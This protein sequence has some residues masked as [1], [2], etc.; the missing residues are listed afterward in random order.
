MAVDNSP[1]TENT[2]TAASVEQQQETGFFSNLVSYFVPTAHADDSEE[3]A[4]EAGGEDEEKEEEE[5]DEPEDHA[6]AIRNECEKNACGEHLNLFTH[7][8]EK[9]QAGEGFPGEDCV[10]ELFHLMGCVD[11]CAAPTIFKKLA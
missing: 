9:V 11:A 6:P 4:E 8:Q 2:A 10:E 3:Q 7:C 5:E 1:V